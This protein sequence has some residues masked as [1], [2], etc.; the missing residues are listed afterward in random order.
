MKKFKELTEKEKLDGLGF[1]S[2]HEIPVELMPF[3]SFFPNIEKPISED[4][5]LTQ[6]KES[7]QTFKVRKFFSLIIFKKQHKKD[8][9]KRK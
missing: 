3:P 5:W 4:D 8:L 6:Y 7:P 2:K 9:E 1:K